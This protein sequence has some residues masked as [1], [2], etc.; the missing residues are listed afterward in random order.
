MAVCPRSIQGQYPSA[1]SS[2]RLRWGRAYAHSTAIYSPAQPDLGAALGGQL[3][4]CQ[5]PVASQGGPHVKASALQV[6]GQEHWYMPDT[7]P[8][9]LL[10]T[11]SLALS[12]QCYRDGCKHGLAEYTH[13]CRGPA[14]ATVMAWPASSG[15]YAKAGLVIT[16]Q[17]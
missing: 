4:Y 10:V 8:F 12:A 3:S 1:G 6:S 17:V 13:S 7:T 2:L 15:P 14:G 9:E 5:S 16:K 11:H